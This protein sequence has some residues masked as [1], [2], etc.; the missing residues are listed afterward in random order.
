MP[1]EVVYDRP[2]FAAKETGP[3]TSG[4]VVGCIGD[5]G[6][7]KGT[8]VLLEAIAMIDDPDVRL[9]I[10]GNGPA[11]DVQRVKAA[12][13]ADPRISYVGY[14]DLAEFLAGVDIVAAPAQLNEPFGRT[15]YEGALAGKH[16]LVSNRGGLPEVVPT[17][18]N[19]HVVDSPSDPAAWASAI[20][21]VMGAP[22][23][24]SPWV[25]HPDPVDRYLSIYRD[26][27][28]ARAG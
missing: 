26:V 15:A 27:V 21:Q 7:F 18:P 25:G 28:E 17:Y 9:V 2:T 10:A 19:G 1:T 22:R 12:A 3:V 11:A 8:Y 6:E 4:R 24:P 13:V 16:V 5:V 14:Q 23:D 20:T